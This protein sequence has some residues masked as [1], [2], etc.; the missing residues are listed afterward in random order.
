MSGVLIMKR[1]RVLVAGEDAE[2]LVEY[3]KKVKVKAVEIMSYL[4]DAA[5]VYIS[6]ADGA[7]GAVRGASK[8]AL[9]AWATE[10]KKWPLRVTHQVAVSYPTVFDAHS[11][12]PLAAIKRTRR[13]AVELPAPVE[14]VEPA[15]VRRTRGTV[16]AEVSTAGTKHVRRTR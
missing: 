7:L 11:E 13:P 3:G 12:E 2:A 15:R 14:E 16:I 10:Q 4:N 6:Y 8:S 5:Q 1:G 9:W